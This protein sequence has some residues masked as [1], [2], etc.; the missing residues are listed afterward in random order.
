MSALTRISLLLLVLAATT[1]QASSVPP[2]GER[3]VV[4][5]AG[6]ML[7]DINEI[8]ESTETFEF[9]GALLLTWRDPREAFDPETE[10]GS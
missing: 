5:K 7:Y 8:E 1:A 3:P 2:P 4:V 6:F 9:E 10:G